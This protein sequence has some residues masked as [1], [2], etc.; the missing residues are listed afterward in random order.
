MNIRQ[1][2]L[3]DTCSIIFSL[4]YIIFANEADEKVRSKYT[5]AWSLTATTTAA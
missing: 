1:K 2:W 5:T 3:R 4:Y